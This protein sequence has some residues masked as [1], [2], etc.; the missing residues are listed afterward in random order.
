MRHG[1]VDSLDVLQI[2]A[3]WSDTR[4][5]MRV[6]GELDLC[7]APQLRHAL[8]HAAGRMPSAVILDL[9][10]VTFMDAAGIR[11]ILRGAELFGPRF[12]LRRTPP[13]FMRLFAITGVEQQLSFEP[14]S[15]SE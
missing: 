7:S 10:P 1:Q 13:Y 11:A 8:D 9:E 4:L 6:S 2:A 12:I 15:G 14:E 5:V 3:A